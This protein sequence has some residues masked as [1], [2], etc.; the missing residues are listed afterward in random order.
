MTWCSG[1]WFRQPTPQAPLRS[2]R[3]AGRTP[4][5]GH[6]AACGPGSHAQ[7]PRGAGLQ[8]R[9]VAAPKAASPHRTCLPACLPARQGMFLNPNIETNRL[10]GVILEGWDQSISK[11]E[12]RNIWNDGA[13]P[14]E[15]SCAVA[16]AVP[17][18]VAWRCACR[19]RAGRPLAGDLDC[20]AGLRLQPTARHRRGFCVASG[21]WGAGTCRS[22]SLGSGRRGRRRPG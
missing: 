21:T 18:G 14:G 6:S 8:H 12:F 16:S 22:P 5:C 20:V 15:G 3:G 11:F 2:P 13:R 19:G 1:F 4:V 17:A 9:H 7:S 10:E